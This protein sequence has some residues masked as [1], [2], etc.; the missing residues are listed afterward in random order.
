MPNLRVLR[1]QTLAWEVGDEVDGTFLWADA[2]LG[3]V[4]IVGTRPNEIVAAV[5]AASAGTAMREP[6]D[7]SGPR[8]AVPRG[9]RQARF[10]IANVD[11]EARHLTLLVKEFLPLD[12]PD[13]RVW[14]TIPLPQPADAVRPAED[15]WTAAD[16]TES[17]AGVFSKPELLAAV[18]RLRFLTD[19]VREAQDQSVDRA[20]A[21]LLAA[22]NADGQSAGGSFTDE[23]TDAAAST[24]S[25]GIAEIF[26][27]IGPPPSS[28]FPETEGP[29]GPGGTSSDGEPSTPVGTGSGRRD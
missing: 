20:I 4:A 15:A 12:R 29:P 7:N 23:E 6:M 21:R 28:A 26:L 27:R 3:H 17:R 8:I 24:I 9:E 14:L 19:G 1:R 16:E 13:G 10:V 18:E 11:P 2:D 22:S 25:G 5:D